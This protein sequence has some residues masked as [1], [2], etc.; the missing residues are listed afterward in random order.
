MI[1]LMLSML[2]AAGS[3]DATAPAAADGASE[4]PAKEKLICRRLQPSNS[5]LS[6]RVCRTQK[7]WNEMGDALD[8]KINRRDQ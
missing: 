2:I 4:A 3:P 6:K 5:R 8:G 7:E 1:T